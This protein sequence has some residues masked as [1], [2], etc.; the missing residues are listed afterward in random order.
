[1]GAFD[2]ESE[3]NNKETMK[4]NS[5]ESDVKLEDEN[6]DQSTPTFKYKESGTHLKTER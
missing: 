5:Y 2:G 1:M 3:H 4:D 6:E